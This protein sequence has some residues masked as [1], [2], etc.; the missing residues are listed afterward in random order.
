[1]EIM[2]LN[3][4]SVEIADLHADFVFASFPHKEE[5]TQVSV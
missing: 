5:L 4:Q 3:V 2:T 1:M